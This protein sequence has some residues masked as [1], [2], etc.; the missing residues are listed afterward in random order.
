MTKWIDGLLKETCVYW[1]PPIRDGLGGYTW[2][3]PMEMESR[4]QFSNMSSK[5]P[6]ISYL[7][8]G[9]QIVAQTV[10]WVNYNIKLGGYLWLGSI[11]DLQTIFK[12]DPYFSLN[13]IDTE[14]VFSL[15]SQ[16]VAIHIVNSIL[17]NT[18]YLVKAYLDEH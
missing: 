9:S 5:G 7:P 1:E 15:A 16:I 10:V 12:P 17:M 6:S 18:G 3:Y 11:N 2:S 8:S 4:W 14:N 13:N